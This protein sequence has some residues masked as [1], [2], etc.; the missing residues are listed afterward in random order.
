ML[1]VRTNK[2]RLFISWFK[3]VFARDTSDNAKHY[4]KKEGGMVP[5][6]WMSPEALTYGKYTTANDVWAFGILM[7]EVGRPV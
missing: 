2:C 7:W 3:L 1:A 5:V 6:K 4:Y